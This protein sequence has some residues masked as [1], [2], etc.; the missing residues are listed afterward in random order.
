MKD[1]IYYW[2]PFISK[3]ATIKAVYNSALSLKK[4]SKNNFE[5]VIL[6]VFGEWRKSKYFGLNEIKFFQLNYSKFINLIPSEKF[7]FSRLKY[8]FIFVLSFFPLK[9]F[10]QIEK[11]KFLIIHLM[12]SLPLFLNLVY[13]L[14]TKIILR[15][16]GKPKLNIIRFYFWKFA[17]KKV[18]QITF[19][20]VET[21]DYF[22][23][24]KLTD[25]KKLSL[26]YDPIIFT[27]EINK[28]FKK[29]FAIKPELKD[30]N[31]F[32]AI[33][34]LTK[35]K[36]FSF[37]IE[38]FNQ[39]IK[40]NNL[41][42]LVIIGEG[43]EFK[44]LKKIIKNYEMENNI[45]LIGYQKNVFGYLKNCEAFI[46]SS[47]WE[48]PGFVIVEAMFSNAFVLSSDC[49]SGPKEIVGNKRGILFKS[50]SKESFINEFENFRELKKNEKTNIKLNAKKFTKNFSLLSHFIKINNIIKNEND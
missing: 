41:I 43:E 20:T 23:S 24:L 28:D 36:N 11:P 7:F 47:L 18:F 34:R 37:L 39:I 45:F 30:H 5:G 6:D 32:L 25:E 19:P 21:M 16:S 9:K 35:Q 8:I 22:K 40:K 49:K 42:N 4:Y 31:F 46:L 33:G 48:D 1:K 10:L 12:T 29:N 44:V 3:V 2:C 27:S 38:C 50:N 17:L 14:E 15:I 13:N 26:L